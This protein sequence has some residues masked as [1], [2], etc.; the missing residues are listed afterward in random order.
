[1]AVVPVR[2]RFSTLARAAR[3]KVVLE[4]TVSVP[5]PI[6]SVITSEVVSTT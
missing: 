1:M 3:E 6:P 2:V 4:A 5:E